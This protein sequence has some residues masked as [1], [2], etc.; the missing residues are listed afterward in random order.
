MHGVKDGLGSACLLG[1]VLIGLG[2]AHAHVDPVLPVQLQAVQP[3]ARTLRCA[4]ACAN[5]SYGAAVSL[6]AE[7]PAGQTP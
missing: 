2:R 5:T 4:E 6:A 3:Q 7:T 1:V